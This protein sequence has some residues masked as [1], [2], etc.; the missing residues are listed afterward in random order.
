M[1]YSQS[2]VDKMY[3]EMLRKVVNVDGMDKNK[4]LLSIKKTLNIIRDKIYDL[5]NKI[6][7]LK[8]D[9]ITYEDLIRYLEELK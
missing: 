4:V 2:E 6:S 3:I 8:R 9:E 1:G 5:E 7:D